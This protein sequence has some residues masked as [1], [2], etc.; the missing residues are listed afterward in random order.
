M[1]Y[2]TA[3]SAAT[4]GGR[5]HPITSQVIP[6]VY[7]DGLVARRDRKTLEAQKQDALLCVLLLWY[8]AA[9]YL[10]GL[11]AHGRCA[12]GRERRCAPMETQFAIVV[13]R[14][15]WNG[16]L[17]L[18]CSLAL[19][20]PPPATGSGHSRASLCLSRGPS[21]YHPPDAL[22]PPVSQAKA[23]HALSEA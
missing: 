21:L 1:E 15:R 20:F 4:G 13:Y 5:L 14:R 23:F 22:G 2:R 8:P 6:C 3:V 11:C 17:I 19:L 7:L 18:L 12:L 10:S 16:F 9:T